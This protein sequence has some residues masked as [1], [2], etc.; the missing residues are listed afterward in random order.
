MPP[1]ARQS[2]RRGPARPCAPALRLR[3]FLV[4]AYVLAIAA[5]VSIPIIGGHGVTATAWFSAA[6]SV[7]GVAIVGSNIAETTLVQL[8]VPHHLQGRVRAGS[9]FA[10]AAL[11]PVGA[12]VAGLLGSTIGLR[13]TLAVSAALIPFSMLPSTTDYGDL[14][15]S[16]S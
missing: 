6:S 14:L 3:P 1:S 9:Q 4:R 11:V 8:I 5:E 7:S 16:M 13:A 10:I 15:L 2:A 12:L